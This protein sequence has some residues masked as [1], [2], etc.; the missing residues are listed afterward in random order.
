MMTEKA[1]SAAKGSPLRQRM[2]DQMRIANLAESAQR[3]YIFETERLGLD[4]DRLRPQPGHHKFHAFCAKVPLRRCVGMPRARGWGAQSQEGSRAAP[5]HDGNGGRALDPRHART[6]PPCRL[7]H[8]LRRRAL[9][10][11]DRDRKDRRHQV[12][13]EVPAHP[14]RQGRRRA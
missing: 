10:L 1:V 12:G 13:Q 6:P 11:R 9:R 4:T 8:R 2:L 14:V 5:P 7:H 3:T